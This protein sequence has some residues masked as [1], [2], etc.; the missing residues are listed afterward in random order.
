MVIISLAQHEIGMNDTKRWIIVVTV[1]SYA[2]GEGMAVPLVFDTPEDAEDAF[3]ML[4]K[5]GVLQ[6]GEQL[7]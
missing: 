6:G 3:N 2:S 7:G 5:I 4:T 1:F